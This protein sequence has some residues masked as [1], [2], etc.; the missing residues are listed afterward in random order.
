MSQ[1]SLE[2]HL[3]LT[4]SAYNSAAF[5][6]PPAEKDAAVSIVQSNLPNPF[7]VLKTETTEQRL[8]TGKVTFWF[9]LGNLCVSDVDVVITFLTFPASKVKPAFVVIYPFR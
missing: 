1:Y 8:H 5:S 7:P 6:A 3:S 4:R 2:R 9:Q